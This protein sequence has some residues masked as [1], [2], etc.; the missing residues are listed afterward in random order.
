MQTMTL[1]TFGRVL[2]GVELG[3][4]ADVDAELGERRARILQQAPLEGGVGPGAGHHL[5]AER[6]RAAV[7]EID[8]GGDLLRRQ[9]ALLD[10]QR[11][12]GL[13]QHLVGAGGTGVVILLGGGV[14]MRVIVV[15]V[16]MIVVIVV[17]ASCMGLRHSY[18]TGSSQ[19]S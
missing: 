6:G 4:R 3:E 15:V 17:D 9:H 19:C 1:C 10:Q 18:F 2:H 14:R 8:L 12:D 7:H 16:V 13:L 5:G 11:A